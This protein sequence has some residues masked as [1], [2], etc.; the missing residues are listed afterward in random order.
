MHVSSPRGVAAITLTLIFT[1]IMGGGK[2]CKHISS[3][4]ASL[5]NYC[6]PQARVQP[7]RLLLRQT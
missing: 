2:A 4:H 3:P 7:C 6:A 5:S 1:L